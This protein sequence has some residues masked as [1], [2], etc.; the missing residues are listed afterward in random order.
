[1]NDTEPVEAHTIPRGSDPEWPVPDYS[2]RNL[3]PAFWRTFDSEAGGYGSGPPSAI[4]DLLSRKPHDVTPSERVCSCGAPVL[5][6]WADDEGFG[7]RWTHFDP[8]PSENGRWF[9]QP[10]GSL[11]YDSRHGTHRLHDCSRAVA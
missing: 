7:S 11:T 2:L 6:C 9:Q 4:S 5:R 10:D 3:S 8:E 1:M